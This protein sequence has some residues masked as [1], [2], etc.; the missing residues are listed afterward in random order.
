[1]KTIRLLALSILFAGAVALA[2]QTGPA[3]DFTLPTVDGNPISLS[4]FKGKVVLLDFWAIFCPPCRAEIPG[5]IDLY[6]RYKDK[7]V[8]I[9]GLSL[10]KEPGKLK[11]FIAENKINYPILITS[12]EVQNDYGK[13]QAIPTTFLLD[14]NLNIVKKHVGFTEKATFEAE[15]EELL[16]ADAASATASDTPATPDAPAPAA[17]AEPDPEPQSSEPAAPAAA[18]EA[19]TTE[20]TEPTEPTGTEA[21]ASAPADVQSQP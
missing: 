7:G 2:A 12:K 13:V 20:P 14:R 9:I 11:T 16:K 21:A 8:E 1:M 4:S 17:V 3:P 6:T 10:D 19:A 5:F 18:T 15:I